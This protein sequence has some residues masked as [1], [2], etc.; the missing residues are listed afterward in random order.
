MQRIYLVLSALWIA[1]IMVAS[2]GGR[3]EAQIND[4]VPG[5]PPTSLSKPAPIDDVLKDP[6]FQKQPLQLRL[7]F[8]RRNYS[9]FADSSPEHQRRLLAKTERDTIDY[10]ALAKQAGALGGTKVP[11]QFEEAARE[12]RKGHS[13]WRSPIGQSL[14]VYWGTRS[15]VALAP[16]RRYCSAFCR[17]SG[18]DSAQRTFRPLP[19][20]ACPCKLLH[21]EDNSS[22]A[23]C[24]THR[25]S[26]RHTPRTCT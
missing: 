26:A 9:E 11:D 16:H 8:L 18:A 13:V 12:W 19:V 1:I 6:E 21:P 10:D 17:G 5:P 4:W 20:L 25:I 15:A 22:S 2:I 24:S 3:P 23:L 14:P 7:E